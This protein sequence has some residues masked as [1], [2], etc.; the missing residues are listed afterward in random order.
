[1]RKAKK[2]KKEQAEIG[3]EII[4]GGAPF[5][6]LPDLERSDRNG[7]ELITLLL[8]QSALSKRER[9]KERRR[10]AG[11]CCWC[12]S[13]P[14]RCSLLRGKFFLLFFLF[15]LLPLLPFSFFSVLLVSSFKKALKRDMEPK[16]P[17]CMLVPAES[18]I[19][20]KIGQNGLEL[21]QKIF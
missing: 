20:F 8:G 2:T 21:R 16:F 13:L 6:I 1:M 18:V 10:K 19:P 15:F 17:L 9:A 12:P 7:T 5:R 3:T 14:A 11:C 4:C